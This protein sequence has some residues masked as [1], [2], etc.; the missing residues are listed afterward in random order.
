LLKLDKLISKQLS[1]K[2]SSQHLSLHRL[3]IP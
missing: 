2:F 1:K 3:K